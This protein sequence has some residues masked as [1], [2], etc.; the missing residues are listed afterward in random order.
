MSVILKPIFLV[1]ALGI[2]LLAGC[3]KNTAQSSPTPSPGSAPP[4]APPQVQVP[5]STVDPSS[6]S[7]EA[8]KAAVKA[9]NYDLAVQQMLALQQGTTNKAMTEAEQKVFDQQLLELSKSV[10]AAAAQGDQAAVVALARMRGSRT[11]GGH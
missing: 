7:L 2:P 9:K 5:P 4:P 8:F 3:H 10:T 1:C 11:H 6:A